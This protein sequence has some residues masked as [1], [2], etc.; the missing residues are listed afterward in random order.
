MSHRPPKKKRDQAQELA[1]PEQAISELS[2]HL[3]RV[4][5]EERKRI[6]RELHDETGQG[7]ML[8]RL[9]LGM[10]AADVEGGQLQ[11]RVQESMEL[12]DRTI[13]GLRRIIGRLSPRVLEELGLVAAIRKEARELCRNTAIKAQ[14]S[15]PD[16]FAELDP[17]VE[18]AAYRC[19]QEALHNVAK[20][21]QARNVSIQLGMHDHRLALT[22]QDDGVGII[23]KAHAQSK[24]F[25][26]TG[27]RE[28]VAALAG[29]VRVTS[30]GKNGTRLT[31]VFP[32]VG[33][34]VTRKQVPGRESSVLMAG[35]AVRRAS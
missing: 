1:A 28:R 24:G 18:V 26:L 25:G 19:V 3:L 8:L 6:S 31:I 34:K 9:Q 5:E 17:E 30:D 27:M 14:L 11:S 7:L 13:G 29:T 33:S 21:S 20:H 23:S 2:R 15:L 32:I 22:I 4:Q 35:A 10:L 12:L 16:D